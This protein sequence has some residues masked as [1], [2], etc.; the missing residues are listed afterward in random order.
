MQCGDSFCRA[1]F[2]HLGGEVPDIGVL[3]GEPPFVT[4]GFTVE[5]PDGRV[6]LYFTQPGESLEQ[7]RDELQAFNFE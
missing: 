5:R 4:E 6:M 7:F 3:F 2:T 1:T